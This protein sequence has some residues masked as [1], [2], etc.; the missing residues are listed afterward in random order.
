MRPKRSKESR[1]KVRG[2]ER[3]GM[4]VGSGESQSGIAHVQ[5]EAVMK[6][7]RLSTLKATCSRIPN[8]FFR[9]PL[10]GRRIERTWV[11]SIGE[12]T[13]VAASML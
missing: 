10:I 5:A 7:G 4:I 1:K 2:N 13:R 12:S 11:Q 3:R 6:R 8:K 9:E